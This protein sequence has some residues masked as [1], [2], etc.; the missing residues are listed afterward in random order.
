MSEN[1]K[2]LIIN[3]KKYSKNVGVLIKIFI[4]LHRSCSSGLLVQSRLS[5]EGLLKVRCDFA[6][7]PLCLCYYSRQLADN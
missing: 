1:Y 2:R 7:T 3:E 6:M 5:V 4:P